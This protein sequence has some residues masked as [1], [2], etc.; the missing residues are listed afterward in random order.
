[1]PLRP[2]L[3]TLIFAALCF[4]CEERE[5]LFEQETF[6]RTCDSEENLC[7]RIRNRT[8]LNFINTKL[9]ISRDEE[10][11]DFFS[12]PAQDSTDYFTIVP[13]DFCTTR[14]TAQGSEGENYDTG[15]GICS[16]G[17]F[18]S[19]GKYVVD[20]FDFDDDPDVVTLI[21]IFRRE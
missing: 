19:Q 4:S 14:V 12:I 1:M 10:A 13:G 15:R 21:P 20:V 18:A 16:V 11:T 6:R 5:A 17:Q 9:T 7:V 3:F 2:T 8:D